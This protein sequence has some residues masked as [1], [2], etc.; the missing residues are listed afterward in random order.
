MNAN[1]FFIA[2]DAKSTRNAQNENPNFEDDFSSAIIGA[3]VEVQRVLGA[4]LL[5]STYA[6]ALAIELHERELG[7]V[8]EAPIES[9]YKGTSVGIGFKAD[10][11]V[12]SSVI[13]E[14]KAQATLLDIHRAQLLSYL[15][16]SGLKLGLLINFHDLP[17]TKTVK[18]IVN[19]L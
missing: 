4:G 6:A 5:E 8:R 9:F 1:P 15:R 16:A 11:I 14:I 10:F 7:F 12:E 13:L 2:Q 19:H 17:L 3:A 18:R